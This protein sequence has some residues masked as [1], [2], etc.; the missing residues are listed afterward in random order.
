MRNLTWLAIVI[1]L[2][3]GLSGP[4]LSGQSV[5]TTRIAPEPVRLELFGRGDS[6]LSQTARDYIERLGKENQGLEVVF[7]DVLEDREQLA[8]LWALAKKAGR[9]KPVVPAFLSCGQMHFGFTNEQQNGA[10]VEKLFTI[11]VYTKDTCPRCQAGKAFIRDTLQPRWPGLRFKIYEITKDPVALRRYAELC[12]SAGKQEG[13]PM[14]YFAGQVIV[15]YQG[16]S[17]TGAQ[18]Q[19]LIEKATD[20]ANAE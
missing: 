19:R 18:W 14:L 2:C 17:I 5:L 15:G 16:D 1:G 11:E 12:R 4:R 20:P 6:D 8:R 3:L 13:L 9:D 7:H 10:D